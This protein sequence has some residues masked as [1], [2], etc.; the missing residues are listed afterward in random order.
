MRKRALTGMMAFAAL[1]T[2]GACSKG[3]SNTD[4][5]NAANAGAAGGTA[6]TTGTSGGD[7]GTPA[8][9]AAGSTTGTGST[10]GM[11][12]MASD[13]ARLD[14]LHRDSVAKGTAKSTKRP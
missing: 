9:G 2:V 8:G 3:S 7:I 5:A 11:S 14:S 10:T 13:S 1:V 4:S 6:G 12:N